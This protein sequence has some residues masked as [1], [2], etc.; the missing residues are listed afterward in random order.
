METTSFDAWISP[1]QRGPNK[2]SP[3]AVTNKIGVCA[4]YRHNRVWALGEEGEDQEDMAPEAGPP[5]EPSRSSDPQEKAPLKVA[6]DP[7]DPTTKERE[8][9]NATHVHFRSWCPICVK[10]KGREDERRKRSCKATISSEYKLFAKRTIVMPTQQPLCT[11]TITP[12]RFYGNDCERKRAS[13]MRVIGKIKE[14]IARLGYHDVKLK[15]DGGP[16]LV[17]VL[18]M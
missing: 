3:A 15:G 16:A 12:R 8:D 7:G 11:K 2:F 18:K 14:R 6:R 5:R 9:H 17:E 1:P 10:A 4:K 13:D